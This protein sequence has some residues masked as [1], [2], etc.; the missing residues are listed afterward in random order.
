MGIYA[1]YPHRVG[2]ILASQPDL[3]SG[4]LSTRDS[5][6]TNDRFGPCSR[7]GW[8]GIREGPAYKEQTDIEKDVVHLTRLFVRVIKQGKLE[9][10]PRQHLPPS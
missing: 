9:D 4:H 8:N 5:D 7:W 2:A 3:K 1:V 6:A 10:L